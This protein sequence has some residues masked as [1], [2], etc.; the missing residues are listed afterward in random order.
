M[1]ER[2]TAMESVLGTREYRSRAHEEL[3][4]AVTEHAR[5][6]QNNAFEH[7]NGNHARLLLG[8]KGI[9]KSFVLEKFTHVCQKVFPNVIP[10]YVTFNEVASTHSPFNTS[11]LLESVAD[12]LTKHY[13]VA[14]RKAS[15]LPQILV[16]ALKQ[17]N[18]RVLLVVDDI[19]QLYRVNPNDK[20]LFKLAGYSLGTLHFSAIVRGLP[21]VCYC[22]APAQFVNSWSRAMLDLL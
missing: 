8:P 13:I 16:N 19:D 20:E 4:H 17:H 12:E 9:G 1:P 7:R 18:K 11:S 21:L 15:N 5:A 22:V 6:L 3:V 14:D 10:I 2:L